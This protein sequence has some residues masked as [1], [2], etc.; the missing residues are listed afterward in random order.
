MANTMKRWQ[1][2]A[3]GRKN[4]SLV[5][6]AIPT[7]GP[8]EILIKVAAVSLNY[9]DKLLVDDGFGL[10]DPQTEPLIPLSDLSGTVVALGEGV[11][12]FATGDRVISTF[13]PDWIDGDGPGTARHPNGRTLGGRCRACWLNTSCLVRSGR[14]AVPRA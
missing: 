3:A 6:V 13:I 12:R 4:L 9:R 2:T 14:F 7:P 11:T 10:P 1:L 5:E 8:G